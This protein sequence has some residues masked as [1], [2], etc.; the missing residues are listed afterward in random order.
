MTNE[1]REEVLDRYDRDVAI[2]KILKVLK[3][4]MLVVNKHNRD[5]AL[6]LAEEYGITVAELITVWSDMAMRI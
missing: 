3:N 2:L 4:A 5:E 1:W 6:T